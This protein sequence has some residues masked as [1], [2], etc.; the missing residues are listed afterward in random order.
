[1][2]KENGENLCIVRTRRH[3]MEEPI[4]FSEAE[5]AR[6]FSEDAGDQ[7]C[8]KGEEFRLVLIGKTGTG[9]SACGNTI[10]G[11]ERFKSVS[12]SK[13]QTVQCKR[14][15]G[16]RCGAKI[17][18]VDTPGLFDTKL[19]NEQVIGEIGKC[20][21]LASPGPHALL[22][23]LKVG[24]FTEEERNTVQEIKKMFGDDAEKYTMVLFT[25][26][27]LLNGETIDQYIE[28]GDDNLKKLIK[29]CG[30]RYHCLE[31]GSPANYSQIKDLMKKVQNMV[32]A[33]GGSCYSNEMFQAV[34][35]EIC[36]IQKKT[37]KGKV[38]QFGKSG[39]PV[40]KTEWQKI[41]SQLLAES[42][43]EAVTI[44]FRDRLILAVARMRRKFR[45]TQE[46]RDDAMRMAE[47][48]GISESKALDLVVKASCQ[49]A[50]DKCKIQ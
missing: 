15:D 21:G 12:A 40:T 49:L 38:E 8:G 2:V 48:Q 27:E 33:N 3:S 14:K 29:E 17:A 28:A 50:K 42:R 7:P 36:E 13:S 1:M 23:V 25:H 32:S 4:H 11:R 16:T 20:I 44:L 47:E 41:Y 10:L 34:E 37:M 30:D 22:L 24:R 5:A 45:V 19:S 9:K 18:V 46:E 31:N 6:V 39:K 35:A 43:K 26:K